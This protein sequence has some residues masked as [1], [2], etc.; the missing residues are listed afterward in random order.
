MKTLIGRL[1]ECDGVF[2]ET[3]ALYGLMMVT[4]SI[5]WLSISQITY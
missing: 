2:C 4:F 3:V 5:M 1:K